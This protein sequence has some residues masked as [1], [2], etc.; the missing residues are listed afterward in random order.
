MLALYGKASQ[1]V[2]Y[3]SINYGNAREKFYLFT[4][5]LSSVIIRRRFAL[6]FNTKLAVMLNGS[7]LLPTYHKIVPA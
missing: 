7:L 2:R 4:H 1:G 3:V 5:S 6:G